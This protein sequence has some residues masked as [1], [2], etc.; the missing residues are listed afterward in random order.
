[1]DAN[2]EA[3]FIIMTALYKVRLHPCRPSLRDS[4]PFVFPQCYYTA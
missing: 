2:L 1:M 4:Y 3:A